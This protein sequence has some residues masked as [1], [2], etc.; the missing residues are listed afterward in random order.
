MF[1]SYEQITSLNTAKSLTPPTTGPVAGWAMIQCE[2]Q[3]VRF[4]LNGEVPTS[5]TGMRLAVGQTLFLNSDLNAFRVI[6]ET[7][8]AKVNVHY[9]TG[10]MPVV[11]A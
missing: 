11:A 5:S 9:G 7:S 2:T 4:L 10:N 6:E 3:A 8:S 1:L